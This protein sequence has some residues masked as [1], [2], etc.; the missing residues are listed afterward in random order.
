MINA[1]IIRYIR[2]SHGC[3][4]WRAIILVDLTFLNHLQPPGAIILQNFIKQNFIKLNAIPNC[5][6]RLDILALICW[7]INLTNVQI[8]VI[9]YIVFITWVKQN[10][11][12]KKIFNLVSVA[13]NRTLVISG[14][15][16]PCLCCEKQ[17]NPNRAFQGCMRKKPKEE[18]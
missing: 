14:F 13:H 18:N 11:D 16:L 12:N 1:L 8:V 9:R 10:D 4:V 6:Q 15:S 5:S 3:W 17:Q 2:N 7:N